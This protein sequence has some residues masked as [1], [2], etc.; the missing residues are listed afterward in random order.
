MATSLFGGQHLDSETQPLL[1]RWINDWVSK[2]DS[3]IQKI[4]EPARFTV[5]L[6]CSTSGTTYD[7][8][9]WFVGLGVRWGELCHIHT[10]PWWGDRSGFSSQSATQFLLCIRQLWR[11]WI[12]ERQGADEVPASGSLSAPTA[13]VLLMFRWTKS[14][15]QCTLWKMSR[16]T[17]CPSRTFFYNI[18]FGMH[19]VLSA[20][21]STYTGREMKFRTFKFNTEVSVT[22]FVL[23]N[24]YNHDWDSDVIGFKL[25]Q[26][27]QSQ[28]T[29]LLPLLPIVQDEAKILQTR[30]LPSW[31]GDIIVNLR[32]Q[33]SRG[34]LNV[35]R[36]V[37][38]TN[39]KN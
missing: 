9:R 18:N 23:L 26:V 13:V 4:I 36:L 6:K 31:A 1:H 30:E 7:D 22:T 5:P 11:W 24:K 15:W 10:C 38:Y 37:F 32:R 25:Q 27:G 35:N 39:I 33:G 14:S 20:W 3:I 12:I 17:K 21:K 2:F 34:R 19:K 28:S 8:D 16:V 29:S